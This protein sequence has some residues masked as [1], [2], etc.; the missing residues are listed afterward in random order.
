MVSVP[1]FPPLILVFKLTS[2]FSTSQMISTMFSHLDVQNNGSQSSLPLARDSREQ[3]PHSS[4]VPIS[5]S[6]EL[7]LALIH[8][9]WQTWIFA[10]IRI[11]N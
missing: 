9:S 1:Y 6:S 8:V 3:D 11:T 5:R 2:C 4:Q 10:F 7:S